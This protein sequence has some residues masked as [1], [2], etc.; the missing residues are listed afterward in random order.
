MVRSLARQRRISEGAAASLLILNG[1]AEKRG[2]LKELNGVKLA[3]KTGVPITPEEVNATLY[4][5]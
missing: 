1:G 4:N 3:P 5:E 2:G